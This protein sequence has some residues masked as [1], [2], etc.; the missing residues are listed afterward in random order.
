MK[1]NIEET[2]Q[3]ERITEIEQVNNQEVIK[4]LDV[5]DIITDRNLDWINQLKVNPIQKLM[6]CKNSLV[7]YKIVNQL[8][9]LLPDEKLNKKAL[10]ELRND[11]HR[12]GNLKLLDELNAT[13]EK[14]QDNKTSVYEIIT[15]VKILSELY[16]YHCHNRMATIR[17]TF[18]FI[19]KQQNENGGFPYS[20][21]LNV[22]IIEIILKYNYEKNKY[23]EKA[24]RWL[25]RNQNS[26]GGWGKAKDKSD[27]WIT[28]KVLNACS[29]HSI[30]KNRKKIFKGVDFILN[31]Y[32]DENKGGILYG[33]D[34]WNDFSN[35]HFN[36]DAFR[37]GILKILEVFNRLGYTKDD[38][39]MNE[40]LHKIIKKQ[41]NNGYWYDE[42]ITTQYHKELI[43]VKVLEILNNYFSNKKVVKKYKIKAGGRTSAK[44]PL[45]LTEKRNETDEKLEEYLSNE[46]E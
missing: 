10:Y 25:I 43:T 30:M 2:K 16:D 5:N 32:L 6:D 3:D 19:F 7:H 37:G 8:F 1:D 36:K 35:K 15:L 22:S 20:F 14:N 18:L 34:V 21:Y 45:F 17:T 28:L 23:A 33:Q 13:I 4:K 41:K 42:N 27:I 38:K 39:T 31:N 9:Q 29:Y 40:Y 26:D 24:I 11:F 46:E 44:K 12:V